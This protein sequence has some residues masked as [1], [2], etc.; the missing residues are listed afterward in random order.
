[1]TR[2]I[3][4]APSPNHTNFERLYLI[5]RSGPAGA[6]DGVNGAKKF[7]D[8]ETP[9]LGKLR[10]DLDELLAKNLSEF[11]LEEARALLS[12]HLGSGEDFVAGEDEDDDEHTGEGTEVEGKGR[13]PNAGHQTRIATNFSRCWI[14]RRSR[15]L[16]AWQATGD[17]G[18]RA[19]CAGSKWRVMPQRTGQP[20][21]FFACTP[22]RHA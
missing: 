20:T 7:G 16:A 6:L 3:R 17:G 22:K 5:R 8:K 18:W 15:A 21:R 11:E 9:D 10:V 14:A 19:I 4:P 13:S 12:K 1:M 2:T